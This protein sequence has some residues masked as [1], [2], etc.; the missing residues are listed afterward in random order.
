MS[1]MFVNSSIACAKCTT[2]VGVSRII[3]AIITDKTLVVAVFISLSLP[4]E[5]VVDSFSVFA[6][7]RTDRIELAK[8]TRSIS[9]MKESR[10]SER[11]V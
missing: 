8:N 9:G 7:L 6:F 5:G 3:N 2:D 4:P 10:R 11:H 1:A